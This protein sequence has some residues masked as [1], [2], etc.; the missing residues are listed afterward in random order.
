MDGYGDRGGGDRGGGDCNNG[1][2]T[3][4]EGGGTDAGGLPGEVAG[5]KGYMTGGGTYL[6]G[7]RGLPWNRP[8]G[9]GVEVGG[10]DS[11]SM[12]HSLHHLPWGTPWF[13]GS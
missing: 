9:G 10:G 8:S 11:Q 3:M 13:S 4:K 12:L 1:A 7:H 2:V 6:Q 5:G